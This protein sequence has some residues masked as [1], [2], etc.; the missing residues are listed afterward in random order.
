MKYQVEWAE[1]KSTSKG[2]TLK[3]T[4]K[5]EQGVMTED[6]TLWGNQWPIATL[7]PG[8]MV[9]GDVVIKQNGQY[10]NKTLYPKKEG[11]MGQMPASLRRAPKVNEAER[12][13]NIQA[14][15]RV[16][17]EGMA[18]GNSVTNAVL[19]ATTV[20]KAYKDAGQECS[21]ENLTNMVVRFRDFLLDEV[22]KNDLSKLTKG[23]E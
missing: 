12:N 16:K 17:A 22:E 18:Y 9:E 3:T 1:H 20:Y 19:M 7:V 21:I 15:M 2:P 14:N 23:V 8:A 10:T 6:V 13:A 5:D 4:L 11:N